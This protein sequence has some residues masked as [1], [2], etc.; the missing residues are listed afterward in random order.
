MTMNNLPDHLQHRQQR[1]FT[2]IELMAV[3]AIVSVLAL[4][5]YPSYRG[6][7]LKA[8]RTEARAALMRTMQQQERYFSQHNSYLAYSGDNPAG[9][10]WYSGETAASSAYQI[11]AAACSGDL[12]RQCVSL[13]ATP[14]GALVD[15]N[16]RDEE[17]GTLS[18]NSLGEKTPGE[19]TRCW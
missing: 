6:V 7:L 11:S 9:F 10:T 19:P 16:F 13:Q 17:C 8:K 15:R 5:A 18:V 1:G 12:I 14:G 3:L 2:L 4:A